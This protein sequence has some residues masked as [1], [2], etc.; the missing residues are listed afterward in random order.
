MF[1]ILLDKEMTA[2]NVE[3]GSIIRVLLQQITHETLSNGGYLRGVDDM[4]IPPFTHVPATF[5]PI[6][7]LLLKRSHSHQQLIS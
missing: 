1:H 6:G 3:T 7:D 2:A 5:L 4:P